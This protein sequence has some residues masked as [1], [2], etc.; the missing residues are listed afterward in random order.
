MR[1][2]VHSG[3]GQVKVSTIQEFNGTMVAFAHRV[4]ILEGED[5]QTFAIALKFQGQSECYAFN[6]WNYQF[7]DWLNPDWRIAKGEFVVD[8]TVISGRVKSSKS[9]VLRNLGPSLGDISVSE[10]RSR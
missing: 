5:G 6:G 2:E 8:V 9:L 4:N 10:L 3:L 1:L 7:K